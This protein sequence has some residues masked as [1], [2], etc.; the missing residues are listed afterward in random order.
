M[1]SG[2]PRSHHHPLCIF[3]RRGHWLFDQ[4]PL[5]RPCDSFHPPSV[6]GSRSATD[7]QMGLAS[8]QQVL[9]RWVV[10]RFRDPKIRHD[11]GG[12]PACRIVD[13]LQGGAGMSKDHLHQV[14]DMEV[15]A[16]DESDSPLHGRILEL[17][18]RDDWNG[19]ELR[20]AP[21]FRRDYRRKHRFIDIGSR[22]CGIIRVGQQKSDFF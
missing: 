14:A 18:S 1:R 21:H 8:I 19:A 13:P 2:L 7:H 15:G 4:N 10:K 22:K 6:I 5:A 16:I 20:A 17:R 3:Q 12:S 11:L 9:Q